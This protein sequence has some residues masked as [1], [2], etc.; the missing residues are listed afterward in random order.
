MIVHVV[1][2]IFT[3]YDDEYKKCIKCAFDQIRSINIF[4]E[5]FSTD[6]FYFGERLRFLMYKILWG[7]PDDPTEEAGHVHG[8]RRDVRHL[9]VPESRLPR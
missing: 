7:F 3:F 4:S 2:R 1:S 6:L 5:P 8:Q 9:L